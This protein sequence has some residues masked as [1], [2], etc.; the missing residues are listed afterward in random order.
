MKD[1]VKGTGLGMFI[2]KNLV[3]LHKGKLWFTSSVDP[4]SHGTTFYFSLPVLKT[5]PLDPH[6]GEGALFAV[7]QKNPA[8]PQ[9]NPKL[10]GQISNQIIKK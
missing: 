3:E 7:G 1:Q 4:Q 5:K 9:I 2:S 8:L 6:E 10:K